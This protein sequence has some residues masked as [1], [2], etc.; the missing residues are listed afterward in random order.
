MLNIYQ[1][2]SVSKHGK[3]HGTVV[4][5]LK[6]YLMHHAP[7]LRTTNHSILSLCQSGSKKNG[8]CINQLVS[9]THEVYSDFDC[10]PSLGV[11]GIFL[12]LSKAFCKVSNA[13]LI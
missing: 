3:K 5:H 12:D 1:S 13:G 10:N 9:I 8:S 2:V 7:S 11:Q 6:N 4:K